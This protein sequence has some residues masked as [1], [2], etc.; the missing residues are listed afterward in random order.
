MLFYKKVFS[1]CRDTAMYALS[2]ENEGLEKGIDILSEV[3]L[4]PVISDEQVLTALLIYTR[5]PFFFIIY[6]YPCLILLVWS[7]NSKNCF[8]VLLNYKG[9]NNISYVLKWKIFLCRSWSWFT[10]SNCK[11]SELR[12]VNTRHTLVFFLSL[13]VE[14]A[15]D[16]VYILLQNHTEWQ[17]SK[18]S[19]SHGDSV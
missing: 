2:I 14:N 7:A 9:L 6:F 13:C 16:G 12:M 8:L 5:K 1:F 10:C 11:E 18:T 3:T 15:L 4:R 19:V 17:V